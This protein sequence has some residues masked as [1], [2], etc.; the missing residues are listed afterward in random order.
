MQWAVILIL[1]GASLTHGTGIEKVAISRIDQ[2]SFIE[3]T[4]RDGPLAAC[5]AMKASASRTGDLTKPNFED[6]AGR[7][8]ADLSK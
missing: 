7:V 6:Q 2:G 8:A 1:W 5:C 4:K 3:D